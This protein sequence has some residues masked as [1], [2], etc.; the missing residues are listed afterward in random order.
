MVGQD[1]R[2]NIYP[3][4][5]ED[6]TFLD[7]MIASHVWVMI[8]NGPNDGLRRKSGWVCRKRRK[9]QTKP[10]RETRVEVIVIV[11]HVKTFIFLLGRLFLQPITFSCVIYRTSVAR[12]LKRF[13]FHYRL[14]QFTRLPRINRLPSDN[15]CWQCL[16]LADRPGHLQHKSIYRYRRKLEEGNKTFLTFLFFSQLL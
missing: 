14:G 3:Y 7:V 16:L 9:T 12:P 6:E 13:H 10:S 15:I 2:D 8:N 1:M 4:Q 11:L 5:R